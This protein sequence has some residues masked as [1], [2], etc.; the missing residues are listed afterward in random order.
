MANPVNQTVHDLKKP[1]KRVF[2]AS[3]TFRL[4]ALAS[5]D[6]RLLQTTTGA[7]NRN[8]PTHCGKLKTVLT[9]RRAAPGEL[10]G[11]GLAAR[12]PFHTTLAAN[13]AQGGVARSK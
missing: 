9:A 5:L 8:R 7:V 3:G 2:V 6:S 12:A 4:R 1:A 11:T 10:G 13:A